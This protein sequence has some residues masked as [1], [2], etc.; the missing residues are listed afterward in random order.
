MTSSKSVSHVK[1]IYSNVDTLINKREE[2][3]DL[4]NN[5]DPDIIMLNEIFPKYKHNIDPL[6]EFHLEGYQADFN[7][8]EARGVIIYIK[9]SIDILPCSMNVLTQ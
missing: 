2:L 6:K 3:A 9:N 7:H 8:L 5:K 1:I 4:V